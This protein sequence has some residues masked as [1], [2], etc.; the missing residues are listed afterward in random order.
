MESANTNWGTSSG[1]K[2]ITDN[3]LKL[4]DDYKA[5]IDTAKTNASGDNG[6]KATA[7][8]NADTALLAPNALT[9]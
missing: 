4:A 2:D 1:L 9:V 7:V 3:A 8:T 6:T 5:L